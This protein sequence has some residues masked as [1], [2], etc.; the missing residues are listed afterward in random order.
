MAPRVALLKTLAGLGAAES[1]P[2]TVICPLTLSL[3]SG[4]GKD[5]V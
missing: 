2:V 3:S 1:T 5:E 4:T